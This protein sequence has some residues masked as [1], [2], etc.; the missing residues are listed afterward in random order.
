MIGVSYGDASQTGTVLTWHN[1][2]ALIAM[3][4]LVHL[5]PPIEHLNK[6]VRTHSKMRRDGAAVEG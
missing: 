2:S 5:E 1:V 6:H 3:Q 4:T